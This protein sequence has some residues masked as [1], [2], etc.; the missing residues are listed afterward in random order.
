MVPEPLLPASV[1]DSEELVRP[2]E[3]LAFLTDVVGP[4]DVVVAGRGGDNRVIPA[5]AGR[6]LALVVPRPFVTHADERLAAQRAYLDPRTS[7]ARRRSIEDRFDVRFVLLHVGDESDEAL[8]SLLLEE[9][10][11]VVYEDDEYVLVAPAGTHDG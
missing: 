3:Q 1:R 9:G 5:L 2:D 10:G 4:T 11:I 7:A 6:T 8:R